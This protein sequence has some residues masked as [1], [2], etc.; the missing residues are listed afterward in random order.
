M[1]P[2]A[3][4]SGVVQPLLISSEQKLNEDGDEEGNESEEAPEES[5]KPATSVASAYRL[6]TPSVK[7]K[8]FH[9]QDKWKMQEII[10]TNSHVKYLL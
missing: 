8:R 10:Y 7:V 3:L 2:E 1:N 5:H 4:E 9:Y 6:L